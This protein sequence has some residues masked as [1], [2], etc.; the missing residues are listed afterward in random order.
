MKKCDSLYVVD[1][2]VMYQYIAKQT[3][4]SAG[5]SGTIHI[6][7]NGLEAI[8]A[9]EHSTGSNGT[10]PDMIMLD[11]NMPV[12]DG[13]G[14]LQNF[15]LLKPR[16]GKEILIYIVSSSFNPLDVERAKTISDVTGYVVKPIT[17]QRFAEMLER[18]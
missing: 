13:W 3:I 1:D 11:L 16:V 14:F 18:N 5:F 2:D 6:F 17:R 9:I 8:S 7:S 12:M 4:E 15:G 10:L